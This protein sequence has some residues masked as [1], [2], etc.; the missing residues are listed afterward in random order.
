MENSA[1]SK[2]GGATFKTPV[3]FKII[4]ALCVLL[5]IAMMVTNTD[6]K[7]Q[8]LTSDNVVLE[9]EN[10]ELAVQ[11]TDAEIEID[12][13][14]SENEFLVAEKIDLEEQVAEIEVQNKDLFKKLVNSERREGSLHKVVAHLKD[15]LEVK[16]AESKI[17]A[18]TFKKTNTELKELVASSEHTAFQLLEENQGLKASVRDRDYQVLDLLGEVSSLNSEVA[19][20]KDERESMSDEILRITAKMRSM[21]AEGAVMSASSENTENPTTPSL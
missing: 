2:V 1:S 9:T 19:Y 13:L 15:E 10:G 20:L 14:A 6:T 4:A 17:L 5:P 11:L 3:M 7:I 18:Q 16:E 8:N 21:E 12:Q